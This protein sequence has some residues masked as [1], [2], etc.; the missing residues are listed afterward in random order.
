MAEKAKSKDTKYAKL[1]GTV[2]YDHEAVDQLAEALNEITSLEA[3]ANQLRQIVDE[4]KELHQFVW[5]TSG[6]E[7]MAIHKIDDDHLTNIMLHLLRTSRPI[8][9]AI[10]GEA[11]SRGI[12]IPIN[13]PID[14][15]DDTAYRLA[16]KFDRE[17]IV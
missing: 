16:A 3:R 6:G 14:W 8:N 5:R 15:D 7:S 13:V 17:D 9:R 12:T 10:R 1:L 4:N 2:D 11:I